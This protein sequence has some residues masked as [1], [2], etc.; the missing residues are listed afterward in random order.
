MNETKYTILPIILWKNGLSNGDRRKTKSQK[1]TP[2]EI[3][4]IL[5]PIVR[6]VVFDWGLKDGIFKL[7]SRMTELFTLQVEVFK[8][9]D[10]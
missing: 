10:E 5:F 2:E 7:E 3:A 9:K 8:E 1:E 4:D 6:G